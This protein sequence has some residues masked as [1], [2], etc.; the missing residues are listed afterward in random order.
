MLLALTL[1]KINPKWEQYVI[2][3]GRKKVPII[4]SEVI[5][6]LYGT[7][8]TAKLFYDNLLYFLT[9]KLKFEPNPYNPCVVNKQ[10]EGSQYTI[11]WH[12][13]D[14][15]ISHTNKE[16]VTKIIDKINEKYGG[17]MPVSISRG[18]I[19]DYLGMVFDY[20]TPGEVM[21]HMYQYINELL[22]SAPNRYR[23]GV[24]RQHLP[25]QTCMM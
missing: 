20:T 3:E 14:L 9:D 17:I 13:D 16:V 25:Q 11:M 23:E 12:V 22:T 24:G 4:Y 18:K 7:V 1:I 6:A 5:K 19:Q 15:K 21:I 2:Y 8:D 10:V